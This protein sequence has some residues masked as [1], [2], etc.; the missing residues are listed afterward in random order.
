MAVVVDPVQSTGGVVVMDAF[1]SIPMNL[2]AMNIEPRITTANQYFTKARASRMAKL[3]GLD[4]LYYNL[5]IDSVCV[6]EHEVNMLL[7]LR[8][9][10]WSRTLT[11][12]DESCLALKASEKTDV[13]KKELG[14]GGFVTDHAITVSTLKKLAS[15][16]KLYKQ[17][18][19][20]HSAVSDDQFDIK[21]KY[22]GKLDAKDALKETTEELMSD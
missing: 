16:T 5:N 1:R 4:K 14:E 21:S 8:A 22:I 13:D 17:Q 7:K 15:L 9:Y 2:M 3:R 10:H 18:I 6:D 11:M 12:F 19:V 20:T